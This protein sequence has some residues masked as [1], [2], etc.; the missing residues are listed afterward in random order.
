MRAAPPEYLHK[1]QQQF[2]ISLLQNVFLLQE[3]RNVGVLLLLL[4]LHKENRE[5]ARHEDLCGDMKYIGGIMIGCIADLYIVYQM[6]L[7][8]SCNW[9]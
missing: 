4:L 6:K 5:D 1:L 3:T 9:T 2:L 8:K 7:K